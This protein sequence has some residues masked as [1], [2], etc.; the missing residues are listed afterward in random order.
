MGY[1]I[2]AER[3]KIGSYY[4]KFKT[5]REANSLGNALSLARRDGLQIV[6]VS[7]LDA[8]GEYAPYNEI[9][10]VAA[11]FVLVGTLAQTGIDINA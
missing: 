4:Y 8:Y 7:S 11:L 2:V 5:E 6:Q 10:S 3:G 9:D 1:L